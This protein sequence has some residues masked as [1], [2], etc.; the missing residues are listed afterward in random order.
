[1][2]Q[3]EPLQRAFRHLTSEAIGFLPHLVAGVLMLAVGWLL[4]RLLAGAARRLV[5]QLNLDEMMA[6]AGW[7]EAFSRANVKTS[8]SEVVARLVFWGLFLFFLVLAVENLGLEL[9]AVPLRAFIEYLPRLLGA[10][11]LLF[12]GSSVAVVLGGALSAS[13]AKIDFAQHKMLAGIVRTLILMVTFVATIEHLGFDISMLTTTLINL[14]TIAA[15]GFAV[16]FA[17]GGREV[18]RNML[19]GYYARERFHAGDRLDLPEGQ[20]ELVAIGTLS[21]EIE[22]TEGSLVIPNSLLVETAV[23]RLS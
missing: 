8:P 4:S 3:L 23:K 5:R 11:L 21:S 18:T 7:T 10:V 17:L 22:L 1:M 9:T 16:A 2:N 13:L 12:V 15:A 20:G 19:A 14:V 6:R